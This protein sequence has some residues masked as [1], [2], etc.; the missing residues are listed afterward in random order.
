MGQKSVL[1]EQQQ[2][3]SGRQKDLKK[4]KSRAF[5]AMS[6]TVYEL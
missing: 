2:S 3:N 6:H 5:A 4:K 1:K